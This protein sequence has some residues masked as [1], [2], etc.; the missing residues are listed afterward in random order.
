[1]VAGGRRG[2]DDRKQNTLAPLGYMMLFYTCTIYIT[3]QMPSCQYPS[4]F[5][6]SSVAN[7]VQAFSACSSLGILPLWKHSVSKCGV[8]ETNLDLLHLKKHC[9]ST[10][11]EKGFMVENLP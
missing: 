8:Q 7:S 2:K 3:T 6:T 11:S 5:I 9:K 10:F 4:R 1:V